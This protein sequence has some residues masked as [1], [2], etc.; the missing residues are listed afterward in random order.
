MSMTKKEVNTWLKENNRTREE[1]Q[2]YWDDLIGLNTIVTNLAANGINWDKTNTSILDSLPTAMELTLQ[3]KKEKEE[4][5]RLRKEKEERE[6]QE[7]ENYENNFASIILDKID[8]KE[9]LS[10]KE[11]SKLV[12]EYSID[13]KHYD[14]RRWHQQVE[15]IVQIKNRYFSVLWDCGLTEMQENEYPYQPTEVYKEEEIVAKVSEIW[16]DTKPMTNENVLETNYINKWKPILENEKVSKKNIALCEKELIDMLQKEN[17]VSAT[18]VNM[19]YQKAKMICEE[20]D[21]KSILVFTKMFCDMAY[22]VLDYV[23]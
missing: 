2:K 7:K 5:E 23:K 6:L 18:I 11:L 16:I 14:K 9:D 12:D 10:K 15:S 13:Y 19:A 8:K 3:R 21:I 20:K 17:E 1:M 4:L 22:E